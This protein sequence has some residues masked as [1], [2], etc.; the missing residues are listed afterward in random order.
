M[1]IYQYVYEGQSEPY[2]CG[3]FFF[4]DHF[5]PV[6]FEY[7]PFLHS[8]INSRG[9][10]LSL[11]KLIAELYCQYEVNWPFMTTLR[12][13]ASSLP[14]LKTNVRYESNLLVAHLV[15]RG[16]VLDSVMSFGDTL[17]VGFA[18]F[19]V[20]VEDVSVPCMSVRLGYAEF[21]PKN[22]SR[23]G[24]GKW[25]RPKDRTI[26]SRLFNNLMGP[27]IEHPIDALS[28][29]GIQFCINA[30]EWLP[31]HSMTPTELTNKRVELIKENKPLW[32]NPKKLSGV[33]KAS[34]LYSELTAISQIKKFVEKVVAGLRER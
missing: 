9:R 15:G 28:E 27:P 34:G 14:W 3:A 26:E 21:H 30:F 23:L 19:P 10:F 4:P 13:L 6:E 7:I 32:D 29:E 33:L 2:D 24:Q 8:K 16:F 11:A 18:W 12:E 1:P 22:R 31:K 20:M 17:H 25:L 5:C